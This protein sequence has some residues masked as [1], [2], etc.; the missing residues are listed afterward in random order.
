MDVQNVKL[1]G[2]GLNYVEE[3]A[4]FV[5]N[6]YRRRQ[7]ERIPY[8][9]QWRLNTEMIKG[10]QFLNINT[11][12][13]K[14][15]EVPKLY[16]WQERE[17]FNQIATIIETRI[18]RLTRQKPI[19]KTRP[20]SNE[21]SDEQASKVSTMVLTSKWHDEKMSDKY[22][23]VITWLEH[24]G[25]AFIKN[26]W[27][28][29]KGRSLGTMVQ[30]TQQQ[31]DGFLF[32]SQQEVEIFEGDIEVSVVSPY[33]IYPDNSNRNNL[34]E[35]RSVIHA[36]A[37]HI[38][39]IEDMYG[40]AV[41]SE[42]VDSFALQS[43]SGLSGMSYNAGGYK[44]KNERLKDHAIVKE[45]YERESKSYPN[46]RFIVVASDKVLYA[47][48]LPYA[49]GEDGKR[50]FP[51]VRIPSI[52][53]PNVFWGQSI[54][55]RCIPIQRRYNA[56][57]NRKAEYLNLVAVG[58]WYE[59]IGSLD[60]DSELNNSPANRIRYNS[61]VGKPEPVVFPSLPSS[62]ESESQTLL[63][64]FT[65]VSGV[66]ELSRFSEAPS[67]VK[68][69]VALGIANEQDDTRISMTASRIADAMVQVAKQWL[70]LYRQF[71]SE[72]RMVQCYG[73][74]VD[75]MTWHASDLNS[76]D[77]IIENSS[78]LAETP[79]QRRQMVFDLINTGIF[80]KFETNP[81]SREGA[82]KILELIE[83]GHW[84]FGIDDDYTLHETRAKRENRM[85]KQGQMPMFQPFDDHDIHIEE[86]NEFRLSADYE[87]LLMTPQGQMIAQIFEQHVQQHQ[88]YQAQMQ[89]QQMMAQMQQQQMAQKQ[90]TN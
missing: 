38:R 17:V 7:S 83:V 11:Q 24:C 53:L 32:P 63:A 62:F 66:S 59:P 78:A 4:D 46:G 22:S 73:R 50:D 2:E 23:D 72:Q 70:R 80:N 85:M 49:N 21:D 19:M 64:E 58:Q 15:E 12:L 45:Y 79:A 82:K 52:E 55:E 14:I 41:N 57:R 60:D 5:N 71:A 8:E 1:D 77:V 68:S 37:Y 13:R 86:H 34:E 6:E 88:M 10:N 89:Q 25:T 84:E 81:Y 69:G 29:G 31:V 3:Y 87:Q 44:T 9:L 20:A 75:I 74:D 18:A 51:F 36:R 33:E 47:G 67:G 28:S 40:V 16:W 26:V 61:G 90:P 30:T 42:S 27:H 39:D 65:A 43:S 56:L 48:D 76:D 54:A 35:C